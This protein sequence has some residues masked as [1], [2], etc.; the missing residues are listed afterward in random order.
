MSP[1]KPNSMRFDKSVEGLIKNI[2]VQ[3]N[4]VAKKIVK[5]ATMDSVRD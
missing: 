5:R 1:K 3:I 4:N 2:E